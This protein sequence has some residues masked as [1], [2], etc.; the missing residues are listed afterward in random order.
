M[1][2]TRENKNSQNA[3]RA[4]AARDFEALMRTPLT[5]EEKKAL[6]RRTRERR[7]DKF[8][9]CSDGQ[10]RIDSIKCDLCNLL[11]LIAARRQWDQR[12]TATYLGTSQA[13]VS[14]IFNHRYNLLTTL[15]REPLSSLW[16]S[17]VMS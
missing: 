9:F 7:R 3:E 5:L 15:A 8:K 13:C 1:D 10:N 14:Q 4:K 11:D 12:K 6:A 17:E 16:T 2:E